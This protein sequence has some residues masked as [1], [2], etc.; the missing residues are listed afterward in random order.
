MC[1]YIIGTYWLR[2]YTNLNN[3]NNNKSI[4]LSESREIKFFKNVRKSEIRNIIATSVR[5]NEGVPRFLDTCSRWNSPFPVNSCT[6]GIGSSRQRAP[7][8]QHRVP[9]C[10]QKRD[11]DINRGQG[12]CGA[13]FVIKP[14]LLSKVVNL[15]RG[16][17][18]ERRCSRRYDF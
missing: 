13:C 17:W 7:C 5:W 10:T 18:P 1:K 3:N 4:N 8:T 9:V 11:I 6:T 16:R 14:P 15:L 12:R 2:N